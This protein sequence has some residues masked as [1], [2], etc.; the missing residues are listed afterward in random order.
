MA[1]TIEK[2]KR[3]NRQH[4]FYLIVTEIKCWVISF[5]DLTGIH[6]VMNRVAAFEPQASQASD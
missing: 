2:E 4:K 3:K 5:S 1:N 6:K